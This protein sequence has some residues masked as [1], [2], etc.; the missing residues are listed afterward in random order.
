MVRHSGLLLIFLA[1]AALGIGPARDA[2]FGATETPTPIRRPAVP[3]VIGQTVKGTVQSAG[4]ERQYVLNRTYKQN[5][6]DQSGN[7]DVAVM[8]NSP[9][10]VAVGYEYVTSSTLEDGTTRG[11]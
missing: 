6:T 1:L 10:S 4:P 2:A 9:W 7:Q 8:L 3:L 5:A 11:E